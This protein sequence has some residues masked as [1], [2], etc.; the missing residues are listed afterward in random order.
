MR[1]Q[2]YIT[3]SSRSTPIE[4]DE[5]LRIIQT[6][7]KRMFSSGVKIYRGINAEDD[8]F[9]TDPRKGG[10]RVSANTANYYTWLMD[11]LSSWKEYPRRSYSMICSTEADTAEIFGY[12]Y[13]VLPFDGAKIGVCSADDLWISFPNLVKYGG[14]RFDQMDDFNSHLS[15]MFITM[16]DLRDGGEGDAWV[17]YAGGYV[18]ADSWEEFRNALTQLATYQDQGL[19]KKLADLPVDRRPAFWRILAARKKGEAISLFF[20]RMIGPKVNKFRL[21]RAGEVSSL[22]ENVEVWTEGPAVLINMKVNLS[23]LGKEWEKWRKRP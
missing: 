6:K 13:Y 10:K 8:F 19:F 14:D 1:L 16:N 4:K 12:P 23:D 22:P 3:E 15:D 2:A 20:D 9:F 11:H 5:A 17:D 21:E 18:Y 7:C